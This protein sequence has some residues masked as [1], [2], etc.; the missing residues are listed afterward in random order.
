L[1]T[2][3]LADVEEVAESIYRQCDFDERSTGPLSCF[4]YNII[5]VSLPKNSP[6][7]GFVAV[8]TFAMSAST[9]TAASTG[10]SLVPLISEQYRIIKRLGG[11]R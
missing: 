8:T 7:T 3:S 6:P 9:A 11:G 1:A 10:N 5:N 4:E 2:L